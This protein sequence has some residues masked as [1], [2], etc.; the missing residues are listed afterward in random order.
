MY[1]NLF[2]ELDERNTL[3]ASTHNGCTNALVSNPFTWEEEVE[4]ETEETFE[5]L[6]ERNTLV[7]STH[8]G[9]TNALVSNPFTWED[10]ADAE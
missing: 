5:E 6:D 9:C 4:V 2:E 1:T 10:G 3:V 8:N 7:A